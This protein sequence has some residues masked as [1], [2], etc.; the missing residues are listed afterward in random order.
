M[1]DME[2]KVERLRKHR[3]QLLEIRSN[4][5]FEKFKQTETYKE[6]LTKKKLARIASLDRQQERE[7]KDFQIRDKDNLERALKEEEDIQIN[8]FL[9]K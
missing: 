7:L 9:N 5:E 1:E 4:T 3:Q 6:R 8:S 2:E